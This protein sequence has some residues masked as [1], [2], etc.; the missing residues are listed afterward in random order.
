MFNVLVNKATVTIVTMHS[1]GGM[2]M[3]SSLWWMW[4]LSGRNGLLWRRMR[5]MNTL[6]TSRQGINSGQKATI[7]G[8]ALSSEP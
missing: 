3:A 8:L 2:P 6:T 4:V 7:N 5:P 1:L